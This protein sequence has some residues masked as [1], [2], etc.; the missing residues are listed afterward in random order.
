MLN[1]L[2][3][4]SC[5]GVFAPELREILMPNGIGNREQQSRGWEKIVFGPI[6]AILAFFIEK[7]RCSKKNILFFGTNFCPFPNK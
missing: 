2:N 4:L 6:N 3:E 1:L 5:S 7:T